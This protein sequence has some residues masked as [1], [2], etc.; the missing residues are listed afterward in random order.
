MPFSLYIALRYIQ[1]NLRQSL[2]IMLAV[3]MGVGIIIFIPSVNLGFMDYLIKKTVNNA[4][5]VQVTRDIET[6]E[7]N[8]QLLQAKIP[9]DA[10]LVVT[11]QTLTRRRKITAYNQLSDKLR[12]FPGVVEVAPYIREQAIIVRGSDSRGVQLNGIIPEREQ[13]LSDLLENVTEGNLD[14]VSSNEVFLGVTLADELGANV[15]NR[16]QIIT[17]WGQK[18]FKVAGIIDNKNYVRDMSLV[19][20]NI[21]GAQQML[22][23]ANEVTGIGIKVRD[24]YQADTIAQQIQNTYPVKAR[25]WIEDNVTILSQIKNFRF[26]IAFVSVMIVMAAASSITSVLIMVVASKTREIGIMKAMG[27]RPGTVMRIFLIQAV[28]L[29]IFGAICGILLA[30]MFINLYN[31]S[32][33]SRQDTLLGIGREPVKMNLEYTIYAILYSMGSSLVASLIP[34]WRAGHLNPVEAIN[35]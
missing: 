3:G 27:A 29:G 21:E 17:P 32:P 26:I 13:N 11:D 30:W 22:D 12:E 9:K 34:A 19:V 23:M 31:F 18:S 8:R 4:A 16:V 33:M 10:Q 7:R 28:I 6:D 15:G 14:T 2:I 24:I 20:T 35:G 5:H 1:Y 25:S